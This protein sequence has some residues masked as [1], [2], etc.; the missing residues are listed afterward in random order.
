MARTFFTVGHSTRPL[1]DFIDLLVESGVDCVVDVRT[2]PRSRT[3]PQFNAETLPA[4]LSQRGIGYRHI[5]RLGGLR[6]R[7]ASASPNS[8]WTTPGFRNYADYALTQPFRE[9]LAELIDLGVHRHCAVMC[10]E[11]VWWRCHRRI[12]SDYLLTQGH[13][14][15]HLMA[16]GKVASATLT[17]AA[18]R[19]PE[20]GLIYPA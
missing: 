4:A 5:P 19:T 3:N 16:P 12:I 2:M 8:Y 7:S 6:K 10:A 11:L 18:V 15:R 14:V 20:G 9:G 1:E 13:E 17:P